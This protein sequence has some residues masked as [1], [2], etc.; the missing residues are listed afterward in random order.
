MRMRFGRKVN[1]KR[2]ADN[3]VNNNFMM[4]LP[5]EQLESTTHQD[6]IKEDF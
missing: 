5:K 6:K 1:N 2:T 3:D 4:W